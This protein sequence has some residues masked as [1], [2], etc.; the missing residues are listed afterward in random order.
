MRDTR[1]GTTANFLHTAARQN[2]FAGRP[3]R[4]RDYADK[5]LDKLPTG[6]RKPLRP[7]HLFRPARPAQEMLMDVNKRA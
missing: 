2:K 3:A 5:P 7:G 1:D 6:R 4:K